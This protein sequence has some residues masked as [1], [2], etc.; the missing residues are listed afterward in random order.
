MTK[1]QKTIRL[2]KKE[3]IKIQNK[4]FYNKITSL[5]SKGNI[6]KKNFFNYVKG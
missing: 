1:Y 6:Y 2:I 4:F 3:E 5:C